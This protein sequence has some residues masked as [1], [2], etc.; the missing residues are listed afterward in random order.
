M[1]WPILLALDPSMTAFGWAVIALT[2]DG[3]VLIAA[4][5][6]ETTP[7]PEKKRKKLGLSVAEDDARRARFIRREIVRAFHQYPP[8]IVAAEAGF[9]SQAA[10]SAKLLGSAQAIAACVID[11]LLGDARAVYV[12]V[13]EAGDA[14]GI[15]RA[16][17]VTKPRR[18][19]GEG[20]TPA[21]PPR[22]LTKE[23]KREINRARAK[24]KKERKNAIAEAVVERF[25][26]GAWALALGT[27]DDDVL[28]EHWEGA[29]DAAAVG[30]AA[31]E[32]PE[33]AAVRAM[34]AQQMNGR[35]APPAQ[36]GGHAG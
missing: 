27:H 32:R 12:T 24:S 18:K 8:A 21:E 4:G 29:H 14:I 15:A 26:V 9:G 25:G 33:V 28:G 1:T 34:A 31:W 6:I 5:V 35:G 22:E 36:A 10:K 11:E 13:H 23:E 30:L 3:P 7:T 20:N 2:P 17:R 16:Q 19:K